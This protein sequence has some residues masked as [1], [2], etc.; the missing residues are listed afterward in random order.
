M[1][2]K[3]FKV[4][5]NDYNEALFEAKNILDLMVYFERTGRIDVDSIIKVELKEED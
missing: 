5:T 4:I 2:K 3:T 1:E